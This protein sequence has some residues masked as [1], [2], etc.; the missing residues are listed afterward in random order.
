MVGLWVFHAVPVLGAAAPGAYLVRDI[1]DTPI[2]A[3]SFPTSLT[4][5]ANGAVFL[6]STPA[7]GQEPWFTDGTAAG[8]APLPEVVPGPAS[9]NV[10]WIL[11]IDQRLFLLGDA[12]R[13]GRPFGDTAL[14]LWRSDRLGAPHLVKTIDGFDPSSSRNLLALRGRA[15]FFTY[16]PATLTTTLWRSDGTARGTV[17]IHRF[18]D[19]GEPFEPSPVIVGDWLL[20][21]GHDAAHGR[22]LWRSD[23]TSGGTRLIRDL[24]PGPGSGAPSEPP[25]AIGRVAYFSGFDAAS[26]TGAL[27]RSDGSAAGTRI[28]T[29][30][31]GDVPRS[32]APSQLTPLDGRCTSPCRAPPPPRLGAVAQRRQRRRH[33]ADSRHRVPVLP[34]QRHRTL[35]LPHRAAGERRRATVG[36][37]RHRRRHRRHRRWPLPR[38]P[39][40]GRRRRR[41]YFPLDDAEGRRVL[42]SSDGSPAG[43]APLLVGQAGTTLPPSAPSATPSCCPRA[44]TPPSAAGCGRPTAP[45]PAPS[46]SGTWRRTASPPRMRHPSG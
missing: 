27:W 14:R 26:G 38:L 4:P 39:T 37:R 7:T 9:A 1:N 46:R 23:G 33:R 3:S 40:A 25:V 44:Q 20:F 16:D 29:E 22:E 10:R 42:W 5:F 17:A 45:P 18:A 30:D 35:V 41:L 8:T 24:A 2:V 34:G 19:A 36:K 32:A 43:T 15:L 21:V 28:V 6:A 13:Q 12:V 11:A 31:F